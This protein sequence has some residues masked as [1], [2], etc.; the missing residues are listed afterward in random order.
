MGTLIDGMRDNSGQMYMRNRYYDPASGRFTQEDPIGLAGGLNAYGFASGDPVSYSDPFGL[1]P[2]K[3]RDG[4][5]RCPGGLTV[6]QWNSVEIAATKLRYDAQARVL[7]MLYEG[8]IHADVLGLSEQGQPQGA[9]TNIYNDPVDITINSDDRGASIFDVRPK[10][11]ARILAHEVYHKEQATELTALDN[12]RKRHH[13]GPRSWRAALE[14]P[15][16]KYGCAQLTEPISD[17]MCPR[18]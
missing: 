9:Q 5:G 12:F 16:W 10:F 2:K 17:P 7:G 4:K 15:A 1:C 3:L 11:L 18:H 14:P 8:E 6:D 13:Y